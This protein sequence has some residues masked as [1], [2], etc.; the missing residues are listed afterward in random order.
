[1]NRE[2]RRVQAHNP[3]VTKWTDGFWVVKCAECLRGRESAPIGID[4]PSASVTSQ[5]CSATITRWPLNK[6]FAEN[7]GSPRTRND[8]ALKEQIG[9]GRSHRD[10]RQAGRYAAPT[11]SLR[12][13]KRDERWCSG[14][15]CVIT[16]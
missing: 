16:P 8:P 12:L 11:R 15:Y 3:V 4:N 14:E 6:P 2:R 13:R 9:R 1:V 7:S 5:R 10:R